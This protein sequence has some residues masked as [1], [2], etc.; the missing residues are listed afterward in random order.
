MAKVNTQ[1]IKNKII[2]KCQE[3][4]VN[5]YLAL[6]VAKQESGFNPNAKSPVGAQGIFQL[7]PA[8]AKGLGVKDAFDIDQNIDGGVRYLKQKL[9]EFGGNIDLALASYNA[10]SGAVRKYRGIPPYKE[11]QNYVKSIK[12]EFNRT[13][14]NQD[15]R[16]M[17]ASNYVSQPTGAS[18]PL[19]GQVTNNQT[20]NPAD[21]YEYNPY[22][23]SADVYNQR[24]KNATN[25]DEL[26][27]AYNKVLPTLSNLTDVE[28]TLIFPQAVDPQKLADL[29][30]Q[31]TQQ[32]LSANKELADQR[33][34][35]QA[36]LNQRYQEL[37]QLYAQDP[38]LVNQGYHIDS[39]ALEVNRGA[40]ASMDLLARQSGR[41]P[42][43][44]ETPEQYARRQ[45]EAQIANQYGVPYDVYMDAE[46]NRL[47]NVAN[48]RAFQ[49]VQM[50]ADAKA[51]GLNDQQ[52]IQALG[53]SDAAK[54]Y[55]DSFNK[56]QELRQ[57]NFDA[58]MRTR[59]GLG[60]NLVT[61]VGGVTQKGQEAD[62]EAMK[63]TADF[64]KA[65]TEQQLKNAAEIYKAN[66]EAETT[67][68]G[69]TLNYDIQSQRV[70]AQNYADVN[71]GIANYGLV[72]PQ[73]VQS[74]NFTQTMPT[75]VRSQI[76]NPALTPEQYNQLIQPQ[77]QGQGSP[78][79][80]GNLL[81]RF[82][83][84]NINPQGIQRPQQ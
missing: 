2:A 50:I 58:L 9:T 68:R 70:P 62:I 82:S 59:Q 20:V 31:R 77:N 30:N 63:G 47:N 21:P 60:Q 29:E 43:Q 16:K 37:E 83:N 7:M 67:Q 8:T 48:L 52:I 65:I 80:F 40:Q 23:Q 10:G 3:L 28:K 24:A 53:N 27:K 18:A 72:N 69:Q 73:A 79:S 74:P 39:N 78:L 64:D 49:I 1:E 38:R 46:A 26:Y 56:A 35:N 51:Q 12:A 76:I 54:L 81:N 36:A 66:T 11:T 5:P 55:V 34:T 33:A 45:Y 42:I 71:A 13:Q 57:K 17:V 19:E 4:G 61:Q 84:F 41:Q 75:G 15:N 22:S 44:L 32:I 25:F 14:K 6:A